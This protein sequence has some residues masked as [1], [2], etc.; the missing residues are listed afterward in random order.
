MTRRSNGTKQTPRPSKSFVYPNRPATGLLWGPILS[1]LPLLVVGG[2]SGARDGDVV[3]DTFRRCRKPREWGF[4]LSSH[5]KCP[6]WIGE[7]PIAELASHG[8][9][10]SVIANS[11]VSS[12][13]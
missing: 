12:D 10:S 9:L 7:K 11:D 2:E 3:G 1:P 6:I 8:W 4:R 5:I 13:E